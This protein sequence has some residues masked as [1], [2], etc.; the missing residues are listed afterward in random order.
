VDYGWALEEGEL[1]PVLSTQPAWPQTITVHQLLHVA[2]QKD[3]TETVRMPGITW[4]VILDVIAR[5]QTPS[6]AV[7]NA[8]KHL[9]AVTQTVT[10]NCVPSAVYTD[11]CIE[12]LH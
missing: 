5:D 6:V 10:V 11:T 12:A 1:V 9:R 8:Q 2:A 3:A 7:L 4:P